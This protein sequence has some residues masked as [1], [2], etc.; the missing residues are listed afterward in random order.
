MKRSGFDLRDLPAE[1]A[2][3]SLRRLAVWALEWAL[4]EGAP[5]QGAAKPSANEAPPETVEPSEQDQALWLQMRS[6]R[7]TWNHQPSSWIGFL[8]FKGRRERRIR[9]WAHQQFEKGLRS[10]DAAMPDTFYDLCAT[11]AWSHPAFELE[12][13]ESVRRWMFREMV[14]NN[15]LER[16]LGF[17]SQ[18]LWTLIAIAFSARSLKRPERPR[19]QRWIFAGVDRWRNRRTRKLA[20]EFGLISGARIPGSAHWAGFWDQWLLAIALQKAG[21]RPGKNG[22][23]ADGPAGHST[24][25]PHS[26]NSAHSAQPGQNGAPRAMAPWLRELFNM[27]FVRFRHGLDPYGAG[28]PKKGEANRQSFGMG[29]SEEAPERLLNYYG[30]KKAPPPLPPPSPNAPSANVSRLFPGEEVVR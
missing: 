7:K 1:E 8:S 25:S 18:T 16:N 3:A 21:V 28:K 30:Y 4:H 17:S 9:H 29:W 22:E 24:N 15:D 27:P 11:I 10:S 13:W 19:W 20:T 5:V 12:L 2:A 23:P 26:A 6:G 14:Y